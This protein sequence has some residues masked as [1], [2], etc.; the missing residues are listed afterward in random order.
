MKKLLLA[1]LILTLV[2]P[3]ALAEDAFDKL[4]AALAGSGG[5]WSR[6]EAAALTAAFAQQ[7]YAVPCL[8]EAAPKYELSLA[9]LEAVL[10]DYYTWSIENQHRFD[11]LM[12]KAGQTDICWHLLP[13]A[14]EIAQTEAW[15]MALSAMEERYGILP[16][17]MN[18]RGQVNVSYVLTD[19]AAGQTAWRFGASLPEDSAYYET[20]VQAGRVTRCTKRERSCSLEAEYTQLCG[21]Q[22]AFYTWPIKDKQQYAAALPLKLALARARGEELQSEKELEAIANHGFCLPKADSLSMQEALACAA[23]AVEAKFAPGA[24]WLKNMEVYYSFFHREERYVWRVIFW[25]GSDMTYHSG[26]VDMDAESGDILRV[27]RNGN[28]PDEWLP[29]LDRL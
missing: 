19:A 22:G 24:D 23:A 28:T 6:E 16:A 2:L 1:L 8:D 10:G 21:E 15:E 7:G 9:L 18:A 25:R 13:G 27:E 12:V 29:Y 17:V 11:A 5:S 14:G 4:D 20:E 26:V 3:A